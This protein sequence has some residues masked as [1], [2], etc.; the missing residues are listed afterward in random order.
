MFRTD[1]L[2]R[3]KKFDSSSVV[4]TNL[5]RILNLF[6]VTAIGI[7]STLGSGIY[8]LAGTVITS[9][10]GPSII[11][12]FVIAGIATFISGL[13][14]AELGAKVPRSG[15]AY[16]YIYVTIGEVIAFI[17][18]WDLILEYV[19]GSASVANAL[20][21]YIDSFTGRKMRAYLSK[22]LPISVPYL[23][24]YPDFLAFGI[25]MV[26][27]CKYFLSFFII[28]IQSFL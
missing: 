14:Y 9:L 1:F 18:G 13:C 5:H 22:N 27:T 24:S 3:K 7:S 4:S 12:S 11:L 10:T 17:M 25:V 16:V 21:Q 15:S 8:V 6:D 26:V 28:L 19:I 20:S 23:G 2:F